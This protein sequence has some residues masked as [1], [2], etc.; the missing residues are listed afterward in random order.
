MNASNN[1]V[2]VDRIREKYDSLSRGQK[3]LA[4][5]FLAGNPNIAFLSA[6]QL[7]GKIGTSRSSL[8]RFA[9]ALG[10]E[11]YL[12][13]QRD[14]QQHF[15]DRLTPSSALHSSIETMKGVNEKGMFSAF[16]QAIDIDLDA[17][18]Q[19]GDEISEQAFEE[20]VNTI[21]AS[22]RVYVFGLGVA[23]SLLDFLVFRLR[24]Y[25][26]DVHP[27]RH[28][29]TE[30]YDYLLMLDKEACVVAFGF[31]RYPKEL[32]IT[33]E[34]AAKCGTKTVLITDDHSSPYAGVADITL[35]G[36]RGPLGIMHSLVVPMAIVNALVLAV[37]YHEDGK[38][39][40]MLE[41]LDD[42]RY[43]YE[44]IV[45]IHKRG[46]GDDDKNAK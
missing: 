20:A 27:L 3:A 30:L 29:G 2:F 46:L 32:S 12:H 28:G 13:L 1:R 45:P 14:I 15:K 35:A 16:K 34:H 8:V 41:R 37:G 9:Q 43:S 11:G 7:A 44:N 31:H 18:S 42:L 38:V 5:I 40:E 39:L 26:L 23:E 21:T 22:N 25:G 24:R 36:Q 17:L 6:A 19:L 4:D 10:Y 33:L